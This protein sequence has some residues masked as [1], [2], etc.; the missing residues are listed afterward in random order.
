[1]RQGQGARTEDRLVVVVV[2]VVVDGLVCIVQEGV[3]DKIN[4]RCGVPGK[5]G[6]D[7]CRVV[8]KV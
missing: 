5:V 2:V 6:S 4:N 7:S 8:E 3:S 1:M